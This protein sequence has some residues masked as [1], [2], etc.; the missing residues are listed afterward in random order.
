MPGGA[1]QPT[2]IQVLCLVV[3]GLGT[4]SAQPK[5]EP[6]K[7]PTDASLRGI[8]AVNERVAWASGTKGTVLRTVDSG[9]T[10]QVLPVP[11]AEDLDFR[12]V[13]AESDQLAYVLSAGPGPKAK[14]YKTTDGGK[15]WELLLTNPDASGFLD[16]IAFFDAKRGLI[17]GDPVNGQFVIL[18]TEDGGKTW[19]RQTT[20]PA[21]PGEGGFAASGTCL[22]VEGRQGA[23]FATGGVGGA[24]V[25]RSSDGGQTWQAVQTPVRTNRQT[26]GI[27]GLAVRG[28]IVVAVGGDYKQPESNDATAAWSDDSGDRWSAI[29]GPGGFRSGVVLAPD[30]KLVLTVGS[31]GA[32]YSEDRGRTWKALGDAGYHAIAITPSGIG[33]AVGSGG[34]IARVQLTAAYQRSHQ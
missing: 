11:N 30:G 4:A 32:S 16:A 29:T 24:R 28:K 25:F 6:Q 2:P 9:V 5:L 19:Q 23:W 21:M 17:M 3:L 10:W 12:D 22:V 27:Y 18:R 31:H 13:H 15:S 20:P 33:W 1:I 26:T 14:L 8:A 34:R 7:S